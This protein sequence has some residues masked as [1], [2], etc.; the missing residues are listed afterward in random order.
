MR[1]C[2]ISVV[3]AMTALVV[4]EVVASRFAAHIKG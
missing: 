1:L 4:S 2:A 3:I